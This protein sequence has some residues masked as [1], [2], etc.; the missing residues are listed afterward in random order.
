ML[1]GLKPTDPVLLLAT[2]G[3]LGVIALLAS[4]LPARRALSV[5]PMVALRYE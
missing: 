4:L 2:V 1:F 3:G 5:D